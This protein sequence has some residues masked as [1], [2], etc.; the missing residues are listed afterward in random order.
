MALSYPVKQWTLKGEF[1][2]EYPS[3]PQAEIETG[4]NYRGITAACRRET[5][6]S[7]G[8]LWTRADELPVIPGQKKRMTIDIFTIH[9]VYI[10]S[11]KGTCAAA[12][13]CKVSPSNVG[14]CLHG[15]IR[16]CGGYV[17]KEREE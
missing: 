10:R 8:F 13:F 11:V 12:A 3:A 6:S 14:L 17:L 16:T 9:G 1:I 15:K 5:H 2:K 7:G 4:I